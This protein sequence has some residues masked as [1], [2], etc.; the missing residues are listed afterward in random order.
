MTLL[1]DYASGHATHSATFGWGEEDAHHEPHRVAG[2]WLT[3]SF[4]C[5]LTSTIILTQGRTQRSGYLLSPI[6]LSLGHD[7]LGLLLD[8]PAGGHTQ[9]SVSFSQSAFH[10]C[11]KDH[12]TQV[13]SL[14]LPN[15]I[16]HYDAEH[17]R[18]STKLL[19]WVVFLPT[20]PYGLPPS[21]SSPSPTSGTAF[22]ESDKPD[23]VLRSGSSLSAI[24]C[25]DRLYLW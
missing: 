12:R 23:I 6:W 3:P 19:Q 13:C 24:W 11:W 20:T 25:R 14:H 7:R 17:H 18:L 10:D 15:P 5:G 16:T 22:S 4:V 2:G 1:A 8:S 9:S 21:P